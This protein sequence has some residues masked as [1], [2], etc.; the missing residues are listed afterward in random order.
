MDQRYTTLREILLALWRLQDK[1]WRDPPATSKALYK[2]LIDARPGLTETE[3]EDLVPAKPAKDQAPRKPRPTHMYLPPLMKY[4]SEFVPVLHLP[5]KFSSLDLPIRL[6]VVL[7]GRSGCDEVAVGFR[8]ESGE[9]GHAYYHVQLNPEEP[10]RTNFC[11]NWLP[12]HLPCIPVF[13]ADP[14]RLL[15]SVFLSLYG[16]ER[17]REFARGFRAQLP[18][19]E[20]DPFRSI[21]SNR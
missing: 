14:L 17:F 9:G 10:C 6:L 3:L 5:S 2:S 15:L 18:S 13:V 8:F 11:P 16:C 4:D 20:S 12:K 19:A 1:A 21:L 7:H